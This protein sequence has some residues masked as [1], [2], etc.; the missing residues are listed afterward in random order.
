MAKLRSSKTD[1]VKKKRKKNTPKKTAANGAKKAVRKPK[2]VKSAKAAKKRAPAKR[3]ARKPTKAQTKKP[4]VRKAIAK[5]KAKKPSQPKARPRKQTPQEK[6]ARARE[7]R[8]IAKEREARQR[9]AR[10]RRRRELAAQRRATRQ[11]RSLEIQAEDWLRRIRDDMEPII[12][13]T[14]TFRQPGGGAANLAADQGIEAA[15]AASR[16]P[17]F[18]V[19]RFDIEDGGATYQELARA[20]AEVER[21][22]I[23]EA[24]IHPQ[25]LSQIRLVFRDVNTPRSETDSV[26]SRIG[27]WSFVVSDMITELVGG[28]AE[29]DDPADGSLAE[30]YDTSTVPYFYV[31][32]SRRV[33][34]YGSVDISGPFTSSGKK[35]KTRTI[36]LG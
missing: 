27:A 7:A 15:V 19:G 8:R 3:P 18:Y 16:T 6:N 1:D 31:F 14:L 25:R 36:A 20:L 35:P 9:E 17:W 21:D 22:F 33:E 4:A 10:N 24:A 2:Q 23:L 5:P 11:G 34:A 30:R 26:V 29:I 32:F 13:T 28:T 12:S